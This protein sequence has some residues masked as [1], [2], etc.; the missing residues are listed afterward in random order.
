MEKL[1]KVIAGLTGCIACICSNCEY[2]GSNC[3]ERLMQDALDVI[4]DLKIT[5]TAAEVL[6]RYRPAFEELAKGDTR[7]TNYQKIKNMG[8]LNLTEWILRTGC[9]CDCCD[10]K[11]EC[12]IPDEEVT[13]EY[14][15][16]HILAWLMQEV[17]E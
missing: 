17:A 13:Q 1:D 11:Y 10:L 4:E 3:T 14:C 5:V 16:E 6:E 2:G 7:Q 9:L 8:P 15:A 12:G